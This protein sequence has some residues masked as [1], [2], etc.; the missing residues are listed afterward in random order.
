MCWILPGTSNFLNL[1]GKLLARCGMC[2][3]PTTNTNYNRMM[4]GYRYKVD[5]LNQLNRFKSVL[6]SVWIFFGHSSLNSYLQWPL[7]FRY[8]P[9]TDFDHDRFLIYVV[10][11]LLSSL[12]LPLK[13]WRGYQIYSDHGWF[14]FWVVSGLLS[15][16]FLPQ[17]DLGHYRPIPILGRIL[18]T[19]YRLWSLSV[20]KFRP[21]P[22]PILGRYSG[23]Y[24]IDNN[25]DWP[26]S[27]MT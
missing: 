18:E 25:P 19:K 26:R 14:R 5:V 21:Q 23:L 17:M 1:F 3:S 15:I 7:Y 2:R 24:A 11:R 10:S 8:R 9:L 13:D 27:V 22:I 4:T 12:S 6:H 20:H 16:K